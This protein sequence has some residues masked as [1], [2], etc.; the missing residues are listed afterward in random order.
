M[1]H[2]FYIFTTILTS[3]LLQSN[4]DTQLKDCQCKN[5]ELKGRVKIVNNFA[6][7]KVKTVNSFADLRVKKIKSLPNECGEW[8]FVDLGEDFTIQFVESF[9]DFTIMYVEQF[10]GME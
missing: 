6:D 10:P 9:P 5:I 4:T 8:Q 2:Y 3:L 7:F 1:K